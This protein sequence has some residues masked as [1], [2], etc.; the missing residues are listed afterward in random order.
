MTG[1]EVLEGREQTVE[2]WGQKVGGRVSS[3]SPQVS[4][5]CFEDVLA[6]QHVGVLNA[7][8]IDLRAVKV[9]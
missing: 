9:H 6:L 2:G 4:E 5:M 3:K 7:V 1:K 8:R